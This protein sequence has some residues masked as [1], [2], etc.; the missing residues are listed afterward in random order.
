MQASLKTGEITE[1]EPVV[2]RPNPFNDEEAD[3]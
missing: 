2:Q 1:G 3:I